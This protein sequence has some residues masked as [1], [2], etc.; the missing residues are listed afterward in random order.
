MFFLIKFKFLNRKNYA[1][2]LKSTLIKYNWLFYNK[3]CNMQFNIAVKLLLD[4]YYETM[5]YTIFSSSYR[6]A[7]ADY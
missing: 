4:W 6:S 3:Y 2:T 7:K 1:Y 5:C